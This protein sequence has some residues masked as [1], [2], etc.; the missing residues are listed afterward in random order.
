MSCTPAPPASSCTPADHPAGNFLSDEEVRLWFET[1]RKLKFP[2][3]FAPEQDIFGG[4]ENTH[5]NEGEILEGPRGD[6]KVLGS[7]WN[8]ENP[9][10]WVDGGKKE[11]YP[12]YV[13][14]KVFVQEDEE[15]KDQAGDQQCREC[16]G[17]DT[18]H[19][20]W[21]VAGALEKH[22]AEEQHDSA[23][24]QQILV[25]KNAKLLFLRMS[26]D[27]LGEVLDPGPDAA[28]SHWAEEIEIDV[29]DDL[30]LTLNELSTE[31]RAI[32]MT[33]AVF[34]EIKL[35]H[36]GRQ[37]RGFTRRGGVVAVVARPPVSFATPRHMG[38]VFG[39]SGWEFG[40]YT[41]LMGKHLRMSVQW[42]A[43]VGAPS[44]EAG[45]VLGEQEID[46]GAGG[47][48]VG[49]DEID[50]DADAGVAYPCS[51]VRVGDEKD[52]L[53]A[54]EVGEEKMA[55]VAIHIIGVSKKTSEVP[56]EIGQPGVGA[57]VYFGA[58]EDCALLGAVLTKF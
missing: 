24:E 43:V 21:P 7:R 3:F 32:C 49:G 56:M 30:P 12:V 14:E 9:V 58:Q 33:D 11:R 23:E 50:S 46:G 41:K 40:V 55:C 15:D 51:L 37:L 17:V 10:R 27:D 20:S 19:E 53:V 4:K 52:V 31:Y 18:A 36:Q 34:D 22:L 29:L 45:E 44:E 47:S 28:N 38:T 26:E 57:A 54:A 25:D 1:E 6:Y 42:A 13:V 8:W 35:T 16:V 39:A 48:A 5:F 2:E